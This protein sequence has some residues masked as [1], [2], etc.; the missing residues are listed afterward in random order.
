MSMIGRPERVAIPMSAKGRP[1][2]ECVT[3]RHKR[4][5]ITLSATGGPNANIALFQ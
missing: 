5:C 2:R 1:E 4:E 3:G